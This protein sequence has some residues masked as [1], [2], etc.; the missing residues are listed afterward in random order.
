MAKKKKTAEEL[1]AELNGWGRVYNSAK[2]RGD[3]KAMAEAHAQADKIRAEAGWSYNEKTG[4]TIGKTADGKTARVNS[5]TN[6]NNA[7]VWDSKKLKS[8]AEEKKE[9]GPQEKKTFV[10]DT[11]RVQKQKAQ[12]FQAFSA[13]KGPVSSTSKTARQDTS[14][15]GRLRSLTDDDKKSLTMQKFLQERQAE[16]AQRTQ[17]AAALAETRKARASALNQAVLERAKAQG[18]MPETSMLKRDQVGPI[19]PVPVAD[20]LRNLAEGPLQMG[21]LTDALHEQRTYK[22][23]MEENLPSAEQALRAAIA[24]TKGSLGSAYETAKAALGNELGFLA[25][26]GKAALTRDLSDLGADYRAQYADAA[27]DMDSQAAREMRKSARM[28]ELATEDMGTVGKFL[29]DAGISIAQNV[30]GMAASLLGGPLGAAAGAA[31]MGASAAGSK[32]YE[33]QEN[34]GNADEAL[35]R[36]IAAG[37]IESV[38]E[39]FSI[40]NLLKAAGGSRALRKVLKNV[41]RQMGVEASEEG[42]SYSLNYLADKL[43]HDP[44]A[45]FSVEE[46]MRNMGMGAVSGAAFG[47]LGSMT[48]RTDIVDSARE[49][50]KRTQATTAAEN[51]LLTQDNAQVNAK[52]DKSTDPLL[53]NRLQSPASMADDALAEHSIAQGTRENNPVGEVL[54]RV[55]GLQTDENGALLQGTWQEGDIKPRLGSDPDI[56]PQAMDFR[57]RTPQEEEMLQNQ[58]AKIENISKWGE[59]WE[60]Y[61]AQI[62]DAFSGNMPTSKKIVLGDT[63]D[64]IA[65]YGIQAPLTMTQSTAMKIA[66]PSG[67]MGG[68]HNLGIPAL[69]QL[70]EQLADPM[71]VL[72]SKTERDSVVVLT[73]W[74]DTEGNPVI[75]PVHFRKDGT[76]TVENVVPSAYGKRNLEALFGENGEN[77]L[78]TK[79]NKS[80]DQLLSSRLQLPNARADDTLV[81]YSIAQGAE[82]NQGNGTE[83]GNILRQLLGIPENINTQ[84]MNKLGTE[85]YTEA[86]NML[87]ADALIQKTIEDM[88]DMYDYSNEPEF[89]QEIRRWASRVA[90]THRMQTGRATHRASPSEVDS[91]IFNELNEGTIAE[92]TRAFESD[93]LTLRALERQFHMTEED[94]IDAREIAAGRAPTRGNLTQDKID[95]IETYADVLYKYN[96]KMK[97]VRDHQHEIRMIREDFANELIGDSDSWKDS[98]GTG[99]L[100]RR[101]PERVFFKVMG[102]TPATRRLIDNY[103]TPVHQ[104]EAQSI[105]WQNEQRSWLREVTKNVTHEESVYAHILNRLHEMP[106][107]SALQKI[108]GDYLRKNHKKIDTKRV[109]ELITALTEKTRE[110]YADINETAIRNGEQPLEFRQNYIPSITPIAEGKWYNR[111]LRGMGIETMADALPTEI[112]GRTATFRPVRKWGSFR[113]ERGGVNTEF[114]AVK[115][116]DQYITNAA[117]AIYHTDD[118][119]NLR[120]LEDAIRYKYSDEAGKA[121]LRAIRQN[122]TLTVNERTTQIESVWD[123]RATAFPSFPSW[124][125]EYTNNLAGKKSFTD[126]KTEQKHGR[127]FYQAVTDIESKVAS[128]QLSYNI[129]SA[130]TNFVPLA[131]GKGEL[132]SVSMAKAIKDFM[133]SKIAGDTTYRDFSDFLTNR[134]GSDRVVKSKARKFVDAGF[135]PMELIDEFTANVLHR[136]RVYDDMKRGLGFSDAVAEADSWTAGLMADR[137]LGAMPNRF[138][139][140]GPI[141]RALGMYQLELNNQYQYVFE[142][143]PRNA[144]ARGK[145]KAYVAGA[146]LQILIASNLFNDVMEEINGR[147][148][149]TDPVEIVKEFVGQLTG[150]TIPSS[151]D[152]IRGAMGEGLETISN[153]ITERTGEDAPRAVQIVESALGGLEAEDFKT[154]KT[155]PSEALY[156]LASN[157]IDQT[158]FLAGFSGGGRVPVMSL[159]P[160]Y[161][162]LAKL[163]DGDVADAIK[164]QYALDPVKTL[165][166]YFAL[167]GG[168]VQAGKTIGGIRDLMQGGRYGLDFDGNRVL[169]Y[170]LYTDDDNTARTIQTLLFGSTATEQGRKWIDSGFETG[171]NA[172]QTK[173]YDALRQTGADQSTVYNLLRELSGLSDTFDKRDYLS[174]FDSLSNK[175]KQ[176]IDSGVIAKDSKPA[177]YTDY[178]SMILS[179]EYSDDSKNAQAVRRLK[180]TYG[181]PA[182]VTHRLLGGIEDMENATQTDDQNLLAS[183]NR[184]PYLSNSQKDALALELIVNATESRAK[185]WEETVK[186]KMDV[187]QYA[188]YAL[189]LA[190]VKK[191]YTGQEDADQKADT[192]MWAYLQKEDLDES[193][194]RALCDALSIHPKAT[195]YSMLT[196]KKQIE[197]RSALEQSKLP[198]ETYNSLW[199]M[200]KAKNEDGT[201]KYKKAEIVNTMEDMGLTRAQ[202]NAVCQSFNWAVPYKSSSKKKSSGSKKS[203]S[204]GG[205][206][207]GKTLRRLTGLPTLPALGR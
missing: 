135:T 98:V 67:Y 6:V 80:I 131:Q 63:P 120:I 48:G 204:S 74:N 187:R 90:E 163:A 53:L 87:G 150:Y 160:D 51:A 49:A 100:D 138:N 109:D 58:L 129:S 25:D 147:R 148:P 11:D 20:V 29:T 10:I 122:P 107:N 65:E 128:Q 198:F 68:K 43:A 40:D 19:S 200:K 176:A 21:K 144:R 28:R 173:T 75:V 89:V 130:I 118:I 189:K 17:E 152:L 104:H 71:A 95:Q 174:E 157:V 60:A 102:D 92:V 196:G 16:A 61:R 140:R 50:I 197:Y 154:E 69:K 23:Q 205:S 72:K 106:D 186:G 8:F 73:E 52:Y 116:M 81:A 103:I 145:G 46:L 101:T 79:N 115:A 195:D 151:F 96:E 105:R 24:G 83:V 171:L 125:A 177:D 158:P 124:L 146:L 41:L 141:A 2:R 153:A 78:Y 167:P 84:D 70:P 57:P 201:Y 54:R 44:N 159:M 193:T 149:A 206:S 203:S 91:Q 26:Q 94:I 35:S 166:T 181:I 121:E 14:L 64:I 112:A 188:G 191:R 192:D 156:T 15:A 139:E 114:D 113:L 37:L 164:A 76:L 31:Y 62:D 169:N 137:S 66:Y 39:K 1:E 4:E 36:G 45:T 190:E 134:A 142:D 132:S 82:G 9:A 38:T 170:P 88:Q 97:P 111:L 180:E 3:K 5:Q 168:G 56:R 123:K 55:A 47:G 42:A 183:I 179:S 27:M 93:R 199:D 33:V 86:E 165:L 133:G 32:M 136:A 119:H 172:E 155:Q 85:D 194:R 207:T 184:A 30:P 143:L 126:R 202:I 178:D 162:N 12:A 175:Q 185:G 59:Q 22:R 7:K 161:E 13:G 127:G 182:Y 110:W 117:H 18:T 77:I 108:A 99:A 34:G